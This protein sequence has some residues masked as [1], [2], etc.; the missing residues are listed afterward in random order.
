M[1]EVLVSENH[2]FSSKILDILTVANLP[3]L[4]FQLILKKLNF[5]LG[6]KFKKGYR[7]ESFQ[8][9][10]FTEVYL[11]S[12]AFSSRSIFTDMARCF[13]SSKLMTEGVTVAKMGCCKFKIIMPVFSIQP[14]DEGNS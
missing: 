8:L 7:S 9:K 14:T 10:M 3:S 2:L 4:F 5:R 1:V 11:H 12:A 13:F 6:Y